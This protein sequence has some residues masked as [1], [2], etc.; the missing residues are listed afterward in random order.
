MY[1]LNKYNYI[2]IAKMKNAIIALNF[3]VFVMPMDKFYSTRPP[4]LEKG[5]CPPLQIIQYL[6]AL[7][8]T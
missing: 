3:V 1:L 8:E 5:P 6:V 4:P 7:W 2:T